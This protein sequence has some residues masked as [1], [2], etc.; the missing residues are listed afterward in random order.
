[1]GDNRSVTKFQ[2]QEAPPPQAQFTGNSMNGPSKLGQTIN[3]F[4]QN[5][6]TPPLPI[7]RISNPFGGGA[8][9]TLTS[10]DVKSMST[11]QSGGVYQKYPTRSNIVPFTFTTGVEKILGSDHTYKNLPV[12]QDM[13]EP[14]SDIHSKKVNLH[15]LAY[16]NFK[17]AQ[18]ELDN[19]GEYTSP[20]EIARDFA[21]MGVVEEDVGS[22]SANGYPIVDFSE[23]RIRRVVSV[24]MGRA[25]C[26]NIWPHARV[27]D[28]VGFV[29]K[30][31][32]CERFVLA[33]HIEKK[34]DKTTYAYQIIPVAIKGSAL[35]RG[36]AFYKDNGF[37]RP[38]LYYH[39]GTV[40]H[41]QRSVTEDITQ[42]NLSS[43]V[44]KQYS[45][46]IVEIAVSPEN[47][48]TF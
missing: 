12:F 38:S 44:T 5:L 30:K 28:K 6:T 45:R 25:R 21:L 35:P 13:T 46:D 29:I 32:D 43:D 40:Q 15:N 17:L 4:T 9:P 37:T 14:L 8:F 31:T 2:K 10:Q 23:L 7:H 18:F 24:I 47:G 41:L 48:T 36:D 20:K 11:L 26:R 3:P 42:S 22:Y 39:F 16:V 1:M 27:G 34:L 33:P 19:P